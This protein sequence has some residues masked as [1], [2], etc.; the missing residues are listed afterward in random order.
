MSAQRAQFTVPVPQPE[1]SAAPGLDLILPRQ[2]AAELSMSVR[3]LQRLHDT[4]TGPPR[5][6]LGKHI[7]YRRA[8]LEQWLARCEGYG[9][10]PAPKLRKSVV[11]AGRNARRARRTA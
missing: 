6:T 8:A 10:R 11:S 7:Y 9:A 5:I 3:T 2:L 4:R 1:N